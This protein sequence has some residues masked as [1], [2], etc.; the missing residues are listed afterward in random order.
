[1][2]KEFLILVLSFGFILGCG[3]KTEL[4]KS[5]FKVLDNYADFSSKMENNDTLTIG[6]NLSMCA[7][8]EFDLIEVTK[9]D[10]K[11]YLQMKEKRVMRDEPVKFPKIQYN[12]QNDSLSLES[13][14]STFDIK[15]QE[16]INSPFFIIT[17]PKEE[18]IVLLRKSGLS[19]R[20][21]N[22]EKYNKIMLD[23]YPKEMEEY[24]LIKNIEVSE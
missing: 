3:Q 10:N 17:N 9:T 18:N 23:L 19:N 13:M 7:W 5:D 6:V 21:I 15:Y 8:E 20:G 16:E 2:K 11:V 14:M 12:P 22:I 1:M 24:K 4:K